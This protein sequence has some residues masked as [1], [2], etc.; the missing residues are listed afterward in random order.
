MMTTSE[1]EKLLE[2]IKQ[3]IENVR[4]C[5]DKHGW[6]YCGGTPLQFII[7]DLMQMGIG[8]EE[9]ECYKKVSYEHKKTD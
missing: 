7:F 3:L 4:A 9:L 5:H 8:V 1:R 2:I 6:E